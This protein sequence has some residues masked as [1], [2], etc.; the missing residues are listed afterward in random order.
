MLRLFLLMGPTGCGKDSILNTIVE[1]G[2]ADRLLQYTTRPMRDCE[3]EGKEY[4]FIKD[5]KEINDNII[6][7]TSYKVYNGDIWNYI[8]SDKELSKYLVK[9][10][11]VKSFITTCTPRQFMDICK[12]RMGLS[13]SLN[14]ALYT[15]PI[16]I[17]TDYNIRESYVMKRSKHSLIEVQR[18]LTADDEDTCYEK[19]MSCAFMSNTLNYNLSNNIFI[20]KSN[21]AEFFNNYDQDSID[22]ILEYFNKV[23]D[24]IK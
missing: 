16:V 14:E 3:T 2:F 5:I 13:K 15:T 17:N 23:Y 10:Y 9:D 7:L 19:L 12:W 11:N 22:E 8:I 18:R 1:H 20:R 4:R 21:H 6:S 24:I